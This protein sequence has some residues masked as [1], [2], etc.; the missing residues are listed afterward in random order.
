MEIEKDIEITCPGCG[1]VIRD[2]I[3]VEI[4]PTDFKRGG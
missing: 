4:D 3:T 1:R 2:T